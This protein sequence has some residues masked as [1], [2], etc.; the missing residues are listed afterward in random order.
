MPG[1][2]WGPTGDICGQKRAPEGANGSF[3]RA[4]G[5]PRALKMR[6]KLCQKVI[7]NGVCFWIAFLCHFCHF[8]AP[9]LSE[10]WRLFLR[11]SIKSVK[12]IEMWEPC[13]LLASVVDSP[14][15][16]RQRAPKTEKKRSRSPFGTIPVLGSVFRSILIDFGP[17]KGS[18][19]EHFAIQND[20]RKPNDFEAC[21]GS[22]LGG[23][24]GV[25]CGSDR[26]WLGHIG[27]RGVAGEG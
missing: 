20:I 21:S 14:H 9:N 8:S 25:P 13:F 3:L 19:L 26:A 6:S 27:D 12:S 4:N 17:K 23:T 16:G 11:F 15:W 18:F 2:V 7:E 10:F 22:A 24:W 5:G 1:G